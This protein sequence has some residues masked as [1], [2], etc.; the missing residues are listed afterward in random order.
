MSRNVASRTFPST[1]QRANT[2]GITSPLGVTASVPSA[3]FPQSCST[4]GAI[5][6]TTTH[7]AQPV[8]ADAGDTQ[9]LQLG[10]GP[11]DVLAVIHVHQANPQRDATPQ[12]FTDVRQRAVVAAAVW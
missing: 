1:S 9:A 3:Q 2:H 10:D 6:N 4:P 11:G 12:R 5:A 8:H 7:L